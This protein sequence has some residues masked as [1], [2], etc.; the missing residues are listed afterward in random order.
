MKK[1]FLF[2]LI[3]GLFLSLNSSAQQ[4]KSKRP[5]PPAKVS[6]TLG[7]G[8]EISIDYSRP[9]LKGRS[10]S[11]LAPVGKVWRTGANEATVFETNHDVMIEGNK[12]P[13]GK[14]SMYTIPGDKEW[15]IIFNKTWKQWGTVYK[16]AED[17]LRVNVKAGKSS[18]NIEML[19]FEIAK[20]GK[21]SLIWADTQIDFK[22]R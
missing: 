16:E 20:N 5:S 19:T 6:Q 12:L 4:D 8:A 7:S 14:Y 17:A 11:A 15:T 9:S 18:E 22:V 1:L 2:T 13:A 21:V 3:T 10:M